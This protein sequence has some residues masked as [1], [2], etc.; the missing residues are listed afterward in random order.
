M[1][2]LNVFV[3]VYLDD[4]LIY[5]KDE[6][7]GHVQAV[8]WVLN[9]LCKFSLYANLKKCWF[10][11]EEV[12]FLGYIVSLRG[13]RMEDE[14]IRAVEQWPEPKSVRDI[15]V[16]L[17]FANF[18]RR[19]IQGF[20]CIAAP[21]TFML[22]T[23][24]STRSVASPKETEGGVGGNSVVNVVGGGEATNP[25]KGKNLAKTTKSKILVKSKNHDFPKSRSEEAGTGFL[26]PK[27]RLAFTQLR[28]AFVKA[29]IL[30]HFDLESHIRIETDASSYAIGGILS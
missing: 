5:T 22:K 25:T 30:H 3:I 29:P 10:H 23:T 13:I 21:L 9:Q 20:S 14:R 24:G 19:F 1:E 26:I 28:Q 2:K 11:Q 6:S 17:G 16:F 7:K 27:A 8:R 4:I 18:Y 15:Q 12:W